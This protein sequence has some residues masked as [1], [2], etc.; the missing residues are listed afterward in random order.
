M[1]F[2][3]GVNPSAMKA[4]EFSAHG[5]FER[6]NQLERIVHSNELIEKVEVDTIDFFRTICH[7]MRSQI[8]RINPVLITVQELNAV[9]GDVDAAYNELQ[10]FIS[11]NNIAHV[12]NAIAHFNNGLAK[13]KTFPVPYIEGSFSYSEVINNFKSIA[14]QKLKE[15][16]SSSQVSNDGLKALAEQI[17]VKESELATLS[18][19]LIE[20]QTLVETLNNTFQTNFDQ[21]KAAET[22]KFEDQRETFKKNIDEKIKG[23]DDSVKALLERLGIKEAEAKQLVNVIGNIGATGNYQRIADSHRT[24][25]NLWR[26][27]AISF[28]V[29]LAGILITTI[30]NIGGEQYD[31]KL[32]LIRIFSALVLSYPATYAAQESA[33]H[34]KLENLNRKA[35]LELS[36]INPFIEILND[37]KKQAIKEK[38]VERYFG[39]SDGYVE[40]DSE[41]D[42]EGTYIKVLDKLVDMANK[43]K[44]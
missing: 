4:S 29:L 23:I 21:I 41:K 28:M 32:A 2:A 15:L 27:F 37:E 10:G 26:W 11:N 42:V 6:L 8:D 30:W 17:K 38:L 43:L 44:K 34:R 1:G 39:N 12:N 35:E 14:D 31:W 3:L 40:K 20:K 18:K 25:A 22:N 36:S 5:V 19:S 33:K 16:S 9:Q 24:A 7:Y 13:A